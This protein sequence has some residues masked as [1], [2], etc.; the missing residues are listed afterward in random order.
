M[1]KGVVVKVSSGV[2]AS[3]TVRQDSPAASAQTTASSAANAANNQ[4]GGKEA[5]KVFHPGSSQFISRP[6]SRKL[7]VHDGRVLNSGQIVAVPVRRV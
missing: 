7:G 2:S 5:N 6:R 1:G 3:A 4:Y